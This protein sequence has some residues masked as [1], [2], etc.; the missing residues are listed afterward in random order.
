[1]LNSMPS[2]SFASAALKA[3]GTATDLQSQLDRAREFGVEQFNVVER[4][5]QLLDQL[6][7]EP[8]FDEP[9]D[10]RLARVLNLTA[11]AS[12]TDNR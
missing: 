7:P 2:E 8:P 5:G 4:C 10:E 6:D 12:G 11:T 9:L 1:M 3:A